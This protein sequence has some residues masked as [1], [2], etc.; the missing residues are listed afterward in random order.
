VPSLLLSQ[1][2]D[3][4]IESPIEAVADTFIA[5]LE[6]LIPKAERWPQA[7]HPRLERALSRLSESLI[8]A[9][10]RLETTR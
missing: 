1:K 4:L 8:D 6:S 3:D 9:V 2:A 10:E 5:R 7:A